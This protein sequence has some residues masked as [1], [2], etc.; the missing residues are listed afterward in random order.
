MN[1][2][3]WLRNAAVLVLLVTALSVAWYA[4]RTV[5]MTAAIEDTRSNLEY[6]LKRLEKQQAE[7]EQVQADLPVAQARL[8]ELQPQAD[9]AAAEESRLRAERKEK[10]QA[11]TDAQTAMNEKRSLLE[12]LRE[13]VR[14]E[15]AGWSMARMRL[16][17]SSVSTG[18]GSSR[19]AQFSGS[20][21]SR[22]PSSAI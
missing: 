20:W 7:Y 10:R 16:S 11:Y 1:L 2:S 22:F 8:A 13:T 19:I 17:S 3:K 15:K 4:A 21:E 9:T 18:E 12:S 14:T 5:T 6:N